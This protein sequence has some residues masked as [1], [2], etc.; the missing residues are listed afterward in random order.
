MDYRNHNFYFTYI[1]LH[2][3]I[4]HFDLYKTYHLVS[5]RHFL[6]NFAGVKF[7]HSQGSSEERSNNADHNNITKNLHKSSIYGEQNKMKFSTL[8]TQN[9]HTSG[10]T[11]KILQ[12]A[13]QNKM[14]HCIIST[15]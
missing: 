13:K 4:F 8:P 6:E 3:N 5:N 14:D 2:M 7:L 10:H 11:C 12:R 1:C 9:R 15:T